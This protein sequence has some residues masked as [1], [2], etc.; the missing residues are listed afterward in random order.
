MTQ[1]PSLSDSLNEVVT[2]ETYGLFPIPITRYSAPN[3]DDIKAQILNWMSTQDIVK[4]HKRNAICHNVIQVGPNNQLIQDVP[5]L[6]Q[7]II[8]AVTCLLYTSDAADE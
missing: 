8:N 6:A 7:L 4:D 3:H 2:Q 5:D 1:T